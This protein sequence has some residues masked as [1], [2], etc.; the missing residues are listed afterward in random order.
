MNGDG[1]PGSRFLLRHF[2]KRS[3]HSFWS[4]AD[5]IASALSC[6]EKKRERQALTAAGRPVAPVALDLIVRPGMKASAFDFDPLHSM[7]GVGVSPA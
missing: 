7:R 3:G 1:E 2:D 4:H 6:V 5:N